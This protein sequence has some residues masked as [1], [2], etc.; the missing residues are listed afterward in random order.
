MKKFNRG[1]KIYLD[2]EQTKESEV[3]I[4]LKC[5]DGIVEVYEYEDCS[6]Y[7]EKTRAFLCED[8]KHEHVALITQIYDN[9]NKGWIEESMYFSSDS[10]DFVKALVNNI[11]VG[12]RGKDTM[13]RKYY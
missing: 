5:R 13:V 2:R 3:N 1:D 10:F 6:G 8:T 11:R 7:G 4:F 12:V 9:I